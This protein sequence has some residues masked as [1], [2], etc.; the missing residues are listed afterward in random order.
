AVSRLR[1]VLLAAGTTILGVIP[2]LQD[3]FWISMA[4]TIMF[5]LAF[6]TILTMVLV[7]VLYCV[8][9]KISSPEK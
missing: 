1:P 9:F 6:G 7:P 3:V 4:V 5:G 2:L 8:L